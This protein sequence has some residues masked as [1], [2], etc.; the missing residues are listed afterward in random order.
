MMN[1][2]D[3]RRLAIRIGLD[4]SNPRGRFLPAMLLVIA[5]AG[6]GVHAL[7]DTVSNSDCLACHDD[8]SLA[9][10]VAG[11]PV[12]LH[13]KPDAFKKSVHGALACTDCHTDIED[14]PHPERLARARCASCHE[15]EAREYGAS[16][17]GVS[18]S[19]GA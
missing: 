14:L 5:W 1:P 16:I 13:V 8:P 6:P 2:R 9:R 11:Q 10:T 3:P 12:S 17:H 15:E 4:G 7:A 18:R 19:M